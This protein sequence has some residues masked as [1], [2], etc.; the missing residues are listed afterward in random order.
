MKRNAVFRI[1]LWTITLVILIG[2][3]GSAM[4]WFRPN[5][6]F[7]SR[8]S[9]IAEDGDASILSGGNSLSVDADKVRDLDIDWV[10]GEIRIQPSD[11]KE[12][13]ITETAVEDSR[14]EMRCTHSG[15]TLKIAYC[16]PSTIR[17]NKGAYSKD[18]TILV[19]KNW[20]CRCLNIDAASA[21]LYVDDLNIREVDVDTASG[22]SQFQNC[23]VD[24]L[25]VDT[26]SGDIRFVGSLNKLD[27][28]SASASIY[29]ELDNVPSEIDMDTASGA[30]ELVLPKNA[31]FSVKMDSMSGTLDSDFPTT[32]KDSR[33][34]CG[35]GACEIDMDSMSGKITIRSK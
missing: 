5:G 3:L 8:V 9:S 34:I 15:Q 11:V 22:T 33:Y 28:E 32:I 6:R 30:L 14:Y 1:I 20:D 25:D 27:C 31:G 24:A 17:I 21:K 19:P 12:I 4:L 7:W 10:S 16:D 18:L 23:I 29:A 26:A 35:D 13:Q 2:L